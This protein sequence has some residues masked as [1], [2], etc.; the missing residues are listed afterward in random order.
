MTP[1]LSLVWHGCGFQLRFPRA[2]SGA[3]QPIILGIQ[4]AQESERTL[5]FMSCRLV[6]FPVKASGRSFPPHDPRILFA[7][8]PPFRVV[9]R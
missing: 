7:V 8:H 5:L 3:F 9:G 1:P 2:R 6:D 4:A